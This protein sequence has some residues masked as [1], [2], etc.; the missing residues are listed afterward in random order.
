MDFTIKE[1]YLTY[2]ELAKLFSLCT[3]TIRRIVTKNNIKKTWDG[4][5]WLVDTGEFLKYIEQFN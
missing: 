4:S 3:W 1:K 2:G 5:K